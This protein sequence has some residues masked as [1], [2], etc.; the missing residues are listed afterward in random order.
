MKLNP[1]LSELIP[2]KGGPGPADIRDKHGLDEVIKLSSNEVW[3]EPFP[4]VAEAVAKGIAGLNRYPD[5]NCTDLREALATKLGVQ[6]RN[7]IFGNGSCEVLMLLGEALLA[8]GKSLVFPDP[9]FVVYRAIGMARGAELRPI[10]LH[11]HGN[12]PA[13]MARA[14]DPGTSLVVVCNP[15]NPTGT[16]LEPKEMR[17]F[18]ESI[19]EDTV[20]ALDEAYIEF[21][22][23][24]PEDS[25]AWVAEYPN[26]IV[27]RTFSKIYGLAG[28]RVG[29][30]VTSPGLVEA[31]DKIRQP[32][33]VNTLSQIAAQAAL[34]E[35]ER[36]EERRRHVSRE[37]E[38]LSQELT[39]MGVEFVDSHTNFVLV[40]VE[41]LKVP[42]EEVSEA[43]IEHGLLTRAGY[44]FGYPGW[45]RTTI[46]SRREN[47][48][49]LAALRSLKGQKS[50]T[51]EG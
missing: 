27:L 49:F 4:E 6:P 13:A 3:E 9:S 20:V 22:T 51:G 36:V 7:L 44:A 2:Y 47:D 33:N 50:A 15:N 21:V 43:F 19:P 41:D 35:D 29:Y 34:N 39:A 14:V 5:G 8:P 48:R 25:V 31:L 24:P 17:Q 26:L 46:G 11:N 37:R 30:G 32:F 38:R 40:S 28:L 10:P 23:P 12:D 1:E 18:L 45:V 16:Y 42:A